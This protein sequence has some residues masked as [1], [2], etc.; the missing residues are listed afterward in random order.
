MLKDLLALADAYQL[1]DRIS[2]TTLSWRLFGDGKKLPALR[3]DA[4]IT[5]KRADAAI[6]W[7]ADHWPEGAIWPEDIERPSATADAA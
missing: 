3:G 6:R 4:D 1:A 2:D 7:F 5:T